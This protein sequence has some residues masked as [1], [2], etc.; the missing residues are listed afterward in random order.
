MEHSPDVGHPHLPHA[1]S[2]P[3][4]NWHVYVSV[5]LSV[6][7]TIGGFAVTWGRTE[8]WREN[9]D[10]KVASIE[11]DQKSTEI[12]VARHEATIQVINSQY[13]HIGKQL[14]R[15]EDLVR[16]DRDIRQHRTN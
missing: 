6:L 5:G 15:V 2:K 9:V 11:A 10:E 16:E 7:V 3:A 14:D 8:Q 1:H 4:S 12:I 13:Q